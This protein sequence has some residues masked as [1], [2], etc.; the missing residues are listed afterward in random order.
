MSHSLVPLMR[1]ESVA[2][3]GASN[4][5]SRIGGRP[6][7]SMLKGKF[8]GRLY[9]VNPRHKIVQGLKAYASIK[10]VPEAVDSAVISVPAKVAVDVIQDCANAGVKS[11]V[12]PSQT[13]Y[14]TPAH[15]MTENTRLEAMISE[16]MPVAESAK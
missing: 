10:D 13:R 11:A 7:Y 9:P 5:P 4:E 15:L 16:A 3:I 12:R 8:Q 6:I 2:V 1:P 14:P